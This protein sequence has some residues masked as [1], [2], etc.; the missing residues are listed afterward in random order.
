MT[1]KV[2]LLDGTVWAL[3]QRVRKR[4]CLWSVLL[5]GYNVCEHVLV[6]GQIQF[7]VAV[8]LKFLFPFWLSA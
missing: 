2:D 8:E 5:C 4:D 6:I 7:L 1:P 3:V